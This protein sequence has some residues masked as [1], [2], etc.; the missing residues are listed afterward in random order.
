M[1][2][3]LGGGRFDSADGSYAFLYAG[4]DPVACVAETL[5]RD[6]NAVPYRVP[7]KRLLGLRLSELEVARDWVVV[8]LFGPS[9]SAI[10]QD[11]WLTSCG[12]ADYP[13][14]R[15]WAAAIRAWAPAASGLV[16]RARH[17]NDRFAYVLF[18]DR[19]PHDALTVVTSDPVDKPGPAFTAVRDAA[20]LHNAIVS[21]PPAR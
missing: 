10:G 2:S 15:R 3:R 19:S 7:A 9:L 14:T 8:N 1:P 11:A 13:V 20:R 21:L 12:P 4:S 5:L 16:W 18:S 6:R 17:D